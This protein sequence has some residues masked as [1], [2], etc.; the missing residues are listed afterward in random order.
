MTAKIRNKERD[1]HGQAVTDLLAQNLAN[2]PPRPSQDV[3][4]KVLARTRR[5]CQ[6]ANL[7]NSFAARPSCIAPGHAPGLLRIW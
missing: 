5:V 7:A 4:D 3:M 2:S 1:S 6:V